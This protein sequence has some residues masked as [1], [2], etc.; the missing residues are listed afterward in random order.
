MLLQSGFE[1]KQDGDVKWVDYDLFYISVAHPFSCVM[2]LYALWPGTRLLSYVDTNEH[3]KSSSGTGRCQHS[4]N[5]V[6][7]G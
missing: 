2:T 3:R 5:Y 6:E 7:V 4:E 1:R